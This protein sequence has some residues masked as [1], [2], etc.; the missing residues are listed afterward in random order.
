[1]VQGM[2][3]PVGWPPTGPSRQLVAAQL[4]S[5][6]CLHN[7]F[8]YDVPPLLFQVPTESVD[9]RSGCYLQQLL[10]DLSFSSR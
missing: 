2:T 3:A 7:R 10:H 5:D 8:I 4:I 1:M 6:E 9:Q